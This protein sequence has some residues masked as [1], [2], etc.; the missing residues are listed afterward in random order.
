LVGASDTFQTT[1]ALIASFVFGPGFPPCT[2][3][4]SGWCYGTIESKSCSR[5]AY[6]GLAFK[7]NGQIHYGWGYLSIYA[8]PGIFDTPLKG[9][10]YETVAGRAII[11]GQT[12]GY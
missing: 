9:F 7:I 10:A 8:A 4:L 3:H 6:M 5:T 2:S 1:Q 11:T 12:S